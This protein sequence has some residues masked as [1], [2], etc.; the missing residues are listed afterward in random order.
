LASPNWLLNTFAKSALLTGQDI[1]TVAAWLGHRDL[2]TTIVYNEHEA[3]DLSCATNKAPW[4]TGSGTAPLIHRSAVPIPGTT[5]MAH[6]LENVGA[7]AIKFSPDELSELNQA[8][9]AMKIK[10]AWL[11]VAARVSDRPRSHSTPI[12]ARNSCKRTQ[13]RAHAI[14][15]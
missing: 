15:K 10:G 2:S 5:Q 7:A 6:M 3:P 14:C 12:S 11:A 13:V 8:V 9:T 4:R 1:P